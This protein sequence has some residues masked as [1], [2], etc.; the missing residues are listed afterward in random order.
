L[1]EGE[2]IVFLS[3]QKFTDEGCKNKGKAVVSQILSLFES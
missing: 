3:L 2:R 1:T